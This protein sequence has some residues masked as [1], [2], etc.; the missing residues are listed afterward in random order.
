MVDGRFR[1]M[2]SVL[3]KAAPQALLLEGGTE[4]E[5][6]NAALYWA[7]TINCPSC[8]PMDIE[9]EAAPYPCG[10]CAICRQIAANECLDLL[11]Y[12]GR[13]SNKADE[14]NP[15]PFRALRMENMRE[16]KALSATAPHGAGKRVAIF[17]VMSELREEALN[18]LLKTLEEPSP[19]TNFVLLA[20]QRQQLLPTLVSRSFCLTLPWPGCKAES[21]QKSELQANFANFLA[22][23]KGFLEKIGAKGALDATQAGELLVACQRALVRCMAAQ[24]QGELDRALK[25]I[26]SDFLA[27]NNLC[28]WLSE[29]QEMLAASV[30]PARV[31]ESFA[32]R[33]YGLLRRKP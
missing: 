21:A 33:L 6:L 16:L 26:A 22:T 9:A 14:E 27:F 7:Q 30:N 4:Q 28:R 1:G 11:V 32:T 24:E 31:M 18:S 8:R 25:R 12:D 13:I 19:Y 17:Q 29:A 15:G 10:E 23:G 20:P 2:L 5:R 3:A